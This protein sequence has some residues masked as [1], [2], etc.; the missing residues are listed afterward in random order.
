MKDRTIEKLLYKAAALLVICGT[1]VR[2]LQL[3]DNYLGLYLMLAG[4]VLGATGIFRHMGYINSLEQRQKAMK[5]TA[6]QL[7]NK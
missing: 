2:I 7:K 4:L 1:L 5:N 3:S 6:Q